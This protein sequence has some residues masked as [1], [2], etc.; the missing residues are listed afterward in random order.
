MSV[1]ATHPSFDSLALR[2]PRTPDWVSVTVEPVPSGASQDARTWANAV[3]NPRSAP[4]VVKGLFVVR[5]AVVPLLGIPRAGRG[6]FQVD[7][8][9]DGEALIVTEDSHL[10]FRAGVACQNG[11]LRVTTSVWFHGTR[12][13]LYFLPVRFG[14]DAVTRAM[15]RRAIA[16]LAHPRP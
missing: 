1:V 10:D 14:H 15:M 3:F 5:Q 16:R 9:C 2:G 13:R 6:V 7:A 4:A 11:F 8:V 12:G